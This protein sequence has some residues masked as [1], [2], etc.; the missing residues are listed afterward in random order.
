MF[1]LFLKYLGNQVAIVFVAMLKI[2]FWFLCALA[3]DLQH[4]CV[5]TGTQ[6]LLQ[7]QG[8]R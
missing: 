2:N 4:T 5:T 7:S 6:G 3:I 1:A 8:Q